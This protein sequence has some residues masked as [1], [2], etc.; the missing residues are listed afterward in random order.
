M[1]PP[2]PPTSPGHADRG[3]APAVAVPIAAAA[4]AVVLT[5]LLLVNALLGSGNSPA[6]CSLPSPPHAGTA[7]PDPSPAALADIPPGY[8]RQYL[9]TGHRYE[10]GW[11][12][13]AAVGKM[14][15]DHGRDTLPGVHAGANSAG[16]AGPMQIGIG[17]AA[18]NTWGRP[19]RH[20]A[21]NTTTTGGT[22][23]YATDG[24]TDGWAD[25]YDPADA[26][27]AA[28]RY[29]IDNGAPEQLAQA[30]FAYNHSDD[31]VRAVL[32][33]AAHY[34]RNPATAPSSRPGRPQG[35]TALSAGCP[36]DVDALTALPGDTAAKILSYAHAQ[37]GKP[38]IWGAEGPDSFDCSGLTMAAYQ[39]AGKTIPRTSFQ[40][41]E[42]GHR[43]PPGHEQP[44]DLVFFNSG[45]NS[46]PGRPGHVGLVSD[47][48]HGL[49]IVAPGSGQSV[50]IQNYRTYPGGP[51]GFTRPP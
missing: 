33:Q 39:A 7:Q 45:P 6:S 2:Q 34:T 40:Q 8:L 41:W 32:A 9:H 20:P 44:G 5:P 30:L 4:L 15:S 31:Y 19:P 42:H 1:T 3:A 13:L 22:G 27:P 36:G 48:R 25:V 50:R 26:V 17:G 14:E 10:I 21:V 46:A 43:I 23:G 49:M 16:A 11:N 35:L 18:G 47:T 38:Y 37:L 29:L 12:V 24:N 28:A 51:M